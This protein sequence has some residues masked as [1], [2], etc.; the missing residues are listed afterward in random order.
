MKNVTLLFA[1]IAATVLGTLGLSPALGRSSD[2]TVYQAFTEKLAHGT[3]D[4]SMKGFHGSDFVGVL[5]YFVTGS[6]QSHLL[7]QWLSGIL[8]PLAAYGAAAALFRNKR[9]GLLFAGIVALMP[10][11]T[12]AYV[13]GYTQASN[14]LFFLLAIWGAARN[15]WWTGIVWA[16]AI[17][18]KPFA[19]IVLP[20]ILALSPKENSFLRRHLSL[21]I[22]L[23][24]PALYVIVQILQTGQVQ[25]GVHGGT[26]SLVVWDDPFKVIRNAAWG[27]QTLFSVH[28]YYYGNDGI[29]GYWNL[30]HTSPVLITLGLF[31]LLAPAL[32]FGDRLR[33]HRTLLASAILGFLLNAI[34]SMDNFYMQFLDLVLILAALPVLVAFPLWIPVVLL[35]LHYQW[36]YFYLD[37]RDATVMKPM[38]FAILVFI[39]L[40]GISW[41][42]IHRKRIIMYIKNEIM[43]DT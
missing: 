16:I 5:V 9:H 10:Y 15:R 40:L 42:L 37:F 11:M 32:F 34:V 28:N 30:L 21:L 12:Y 38:V 25:V 4:L 14:I 31:A 8:L 35:T 43:L 24:L 7:F 36:F 3:L 39:D 6:P 23:G 19:I 17:T 1:L 26:E 18:T 29:T 27:V 13:T 41:C 20:L 22:G 2:Y 33:L